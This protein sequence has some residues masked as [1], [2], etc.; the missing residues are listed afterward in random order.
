MTKIN[1]TYSTHTPLIIIQFGNEPIRNN[2]DA[3]S[4]VHAKEHD[5]HQKTLG[6]RKDP[7]TEQID[8]Y[9]H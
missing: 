8:N 3:K 6:T 2:K 9:S 7:G 1:K 4:Y 5:D